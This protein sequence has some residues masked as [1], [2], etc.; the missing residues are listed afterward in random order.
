MYHLAHWADQLQYGTRMPSRGRE[1]DLDLHRQKAG[2]EPATLQARLMCV[3]VQR[4][5]PIELPPGEE[6]CAFVKQHA[7]DGLKSCSSASGRCYGF[8]R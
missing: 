2:I 8:S 7:E 4:A 6:D 1:S 5:L 3:I